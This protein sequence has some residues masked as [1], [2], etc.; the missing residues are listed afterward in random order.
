MLHQKIIWVRSDARRRVRYLAGNPLWPLQ[1]LY[2]LRNPPFV[3]DPEFTP[4][5]IDAL[6]CDPK[7]APASP[8]NLKQ[9][10]PSKHRGLRT[11]RR[12]FPIPQLVAGLSWRFA[13]HIKPPV[14]PETEFAPLDLSYISRQ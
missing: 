13:Q 1:E 9:V 8:S 3:A 14:V 11:I 5:D 12:E 6:A 10:C 4:F 7:S 2:D